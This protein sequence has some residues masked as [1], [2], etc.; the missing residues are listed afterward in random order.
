MQ[1]K[2]NNLNEYDE[3]FKLLRS[4]LEI[5]IKISDNN[6]N[7]IQDEVIYKYA[8]RNTVLLD[9]GSIESS[10]RYLVDGVIKIIYNDHTSY[11]FDFRTKGDFLCDAQSFLKNKET[12][13]TFE[14]VTEC[15]W[16]EIKAIDFVPILQAN[17]ELMSSMTQKIA[18]YAQRGHERAAFL[19]I[20]SAEDRYCEFCKTHTEVIKYAKLGDIASFLDITPQSLSR[21]RKK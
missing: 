14:A 17:N 10:A 21:I 12:I 15:K 8:A 9:C 18:D 4:S 11:V 1:K 16:M 13:Y 7:Q 2:N 19:R 20:N 5:D 6:W 3:A